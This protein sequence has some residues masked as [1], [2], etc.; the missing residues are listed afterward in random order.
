[1][2]PTCS[3]SSGK[4]ITTLATTTAISSTIWMVRGVPPRMYPTLKSCS[5]S[6]ATA[7]ETHTTAATPSTATTPLVPET[8]SD[9]ISSAAITSVESVKPGNRIVRRAD[10]AHQVARRPWRR[11]S[12]RSASPAPPRSRRR[13]CPTD[14][15][16]AR[17]SAGRSRRSAPKTVFE[18]MYRSVRPTVFRLPA[19][20][21]SVR[22]TPWPGRRSGSCACGTACS[23]CPPSCR[24]PRSA[25]RCSATRRSPGRASPR[26]ARRPAGYVCNCGPRKE[27]QQRNQ[28]SP[29]DHAAREVQ[30]RQ[31][32]SDDVAHADDRPG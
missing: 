32:R 2:L 20:R 10:H 16:R 29:G 24:P 3:H 12:R 27:D 25:A 9:T 18:L 22:K 31:L 1:M 21:P 14:R 30:R 26:R 17:T 5:S 28:Q 8:P 11:R 6:P 23:R 13:S 7:D 4:Y 15:C 19:P